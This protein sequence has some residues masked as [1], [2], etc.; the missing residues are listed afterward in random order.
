MKRDGVSLHRDYEGG[1]L[2]K[3][4]RIRQTDDIIL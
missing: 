4:H 3:E 2:R 1:G